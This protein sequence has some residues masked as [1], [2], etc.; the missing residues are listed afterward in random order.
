MVRRCGSTFDP[1]SHH[2]VAIGTKRERD[3]LFTMLAYLAVHI[4]SPS[5]DAITACEPGDEERRQAVVIERARRENIVVRRRLESLDEVPALAP[6][7][8]K[9][10]TPAD[11]PAS[12]ELH[13]RGSSCPTM[14]WMWLNIECRENG[15]SVIEDDRMDVAGARDS[16][17]P[18]P[19]RL[20]AEKDQERGDDGSPGRPSQH[21]PRGLYAGEHDEGKPPRRGS[22]S[23]L[24]ARA[25]A[26][27][28]RSRIL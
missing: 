6:A 22:E 12:V 28:S 10:T 25:T 4:A 17:F 19:Y 2:E 20:G 5:H 23:Y 3:G 11:P 21:R 9:A 16:N 13:E 26:A 15:A 18:R 1:T 7:S 27:D 14:A 24:C 8:T